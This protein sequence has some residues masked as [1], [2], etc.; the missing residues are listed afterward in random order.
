[1]KCVYAIDKNPNARELAKERGAA[2]T[3]ENVK[4]IAQF[5]PEVIIDLNQS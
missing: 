4:E 5:E 1:M 2:G 3:F